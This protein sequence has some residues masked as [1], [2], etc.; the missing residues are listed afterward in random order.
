MIGFVLLGLLFG[1]ALSRAGATRFDAIHSMFLLDD[2]H[3]VGVIAVAIGVSALGYA[4]F[5]RGA[6]HVRSGG[7]PNL[8]PKPM[9][10]GLVIGALLF[11][12]GW[13]LTGSCPGA[14]LAQI[15]EGT[16]AG[17]IT[18]A[19]ILIGTRLARA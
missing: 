10:R 5:R 1:F 18:F 13:A 2:L 9:Q 8:R 4:L 12:V 11:G 7:E 17:L 14:A 16:L 15:G 6:L 3:L 19:G